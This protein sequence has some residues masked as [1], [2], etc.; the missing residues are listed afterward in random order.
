VPRDREA[1]SSPCSS[2]TSARFKRYVSSG[3]QSYSLGT[4]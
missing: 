2:N 4:S 3:A 1:S